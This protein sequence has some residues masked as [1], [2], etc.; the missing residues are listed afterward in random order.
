MQSHTRY[1]EHAKRK[2]VTAMSYTRSNVKAVPYMVSEVNLPL[3]THIL[4][5]KKALIR[6]TKY[7]LL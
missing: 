6:A 3:Q 7:I 2:T 5:I 1:T 4:N